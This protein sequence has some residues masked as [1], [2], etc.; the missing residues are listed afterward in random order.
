MLFLD[1]LTTT[2]TG[3]CSTESDYLATVMRQFGLA[4]DYCLLDVAG[5]QIDGIDYDV[6]LDRVG[7]S[8][9][10]ININGYV[11]DPNILAIAKRRVYLDVDP[12]FAQMWR[13]CGLH[14]SFANH[15]V[16]VTI[17]EN[18][19]KSDCHVPTCGLDWITTR[20]PVV[21]EAWPSVE[22]DVTAFTTVGAWRGPFAP[23]EF[24]GKRFGLRVH[25]FRRFLDLPRLTGQRFELALDIHDAD[26]PDLEMLRRT[27]WA[28]ESLEREIAEERAAIEAE[29]ARLMRN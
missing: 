15:D 12:G 2:D 20:Q 7:G 19:G 5:K 25:E 22:R 8:E 24:G 3:N 6:A 17:A 11:D 9:M 1:R 21:L 29:R 23:I 13:E 27:A 14:D 10:L 26:V 18:I 16:F 28:G 4:N